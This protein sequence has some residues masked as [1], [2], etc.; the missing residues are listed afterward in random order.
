MLGGN[1]PWVT[2]NSNATIIG[3]A[4]PGKVVATIS[5]GLNELDIFSNT[6]LTP[7]VFYYIALTWN[8]PAQE[9]KHLD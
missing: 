4:G 2:Y 5:D 6:A 1:T 9:R 3:T 8:G 7:G